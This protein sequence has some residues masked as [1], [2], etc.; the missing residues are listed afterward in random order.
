MRVD[1]AIS[2]IAASQHG[3]VTRAQLLAA[4]HRANAIHRRVLRGYLR[5][6]QRGVYQVGPVAAPLGRIMAAVLASSGGRG[7]ARAGAVVSHHT[8]A[9]LRR[10][11][12]PK[13]AAEPVDVLVPGMARGRRPGV[14]A[15]RVDRLE[16]DETALLEGIPVTTA[17]RTLLD[18]AAGITTRELERLVAHA[19]REGLATHAEL[20]L[21]VERHARRRGAAAL[22]RIL[23]AQGGPQLTRSEAESQLLALVRRARLTP[24]AVNVR[25]A[26]YEV[27]FLWHVERLVVEVDGFAFH[28]S[29]RAFERDRRRDAALTAAGFRVLRVTWRQIVG[30]PELLLATLVQA[31]LR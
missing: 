15:H 5:P 26:G 20:A 1:I 3:L 17:A 18:L 28:S 30:E 10:L 27:D 19:D 22:L 4:G 24:P 12:S 14:R 16:A 9:G 13:P 8:A 11:Q 25:V 21:L 29:A 7:A 2:E 31:L 6:L 23:G